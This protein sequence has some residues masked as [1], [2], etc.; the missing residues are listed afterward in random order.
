MERAE[1]G[2]YRKIAAAA[3]ALALCLSGCSA[4][5]SCPPATSAPTDQSERTAELEARLAAAEEELERLEN[6][7]MFGEYAYYTMV[8]IEPEFSQAIVN[9]EEG[10]LTSPVEPGLKCGHRMVN[11]YAEVVAK[12]RIAANTELIEPPE[13]WLL[14]Q[15]SA[16]D[17][18]EGGLGW[19]PAGCAVEYTAENMETITFPLRIDESRME[20]NYGSV[21]V[22]VETL[23]NDMVD[24]G[25][26][27]GG[28]A[29][30]PADCIIRPTP[31]VTGWFYT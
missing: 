22:D 6:Q 29:S 9:C 5:T 30:V 27:G 15:C 16:M 24:I 25:Y 8:R 3:L 26:H 14:I 13:E 1:T 4:E 18:T 12:C 7:S 17:A 11:E 19:I 23:G 28:T 20:W 10:I 31:G 21:S 2:V